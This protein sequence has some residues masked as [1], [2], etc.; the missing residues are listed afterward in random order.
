MPPLEC[1]LPLDR[2]PEVTLAHGDGGRLTHQLVDELFLAAFDDAAL[3]ERHDGAVLAPPSGRLAF[4]T[5]A[6]VVRPLFFPGG[7]I[8][9]LAV[10]GTV[11]DLAMCGARPLYLSAAFVLE[12][13]LPI[14]TLWRVAC[15]MAEAAREV[16]VRIVTGD[17]KVVERGRGDGLYVTTAGVGEL[18]SPA[19]IAPAAVRPGDAV[20]LSGDPGRHGVAVLAVREGLRLEPPLASDVA[21]LAAPVADLLA[22]GA[23]V[24]CLRDATRG[25]LATALAEIAASAGLELEVEEAAIPLSPGVRSACELL[26]IDPLYVA[27]EGC[28]VAFVPERDEERALAALRSHAVSAK[29]RRIGR[30]LAAPAGRAVARTA[31]GT[32]RLLGLRSGAALPRI[33]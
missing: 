15:S 6:Y 25:G 27:S 30:V 3:S 19:A 31:L 20:L 13:G 12:E 22:S 21:A 5:D 32:R 33:C 8:G 24:H 18:A 28:F 2:Y 17:T 16:G 23:E 1:P 4:T 10:F 11:N 9:R 14:E 7:D 26:G 29:A